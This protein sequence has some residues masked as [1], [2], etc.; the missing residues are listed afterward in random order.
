VGDKFHGF[1]KKIYPEKTDGGDRF[2]I[3]VAAGKPGYNRVEDEAGKVLRLLKENGGY[4]PYNIKVIRKL[5]T[6]FLE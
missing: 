3:D 6:I 2:R 5:F 4:L 1:I